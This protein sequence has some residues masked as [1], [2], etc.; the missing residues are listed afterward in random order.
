LAVPAPRIIPGVLGQVKFNSLSPNV[1]Q[2]SKML[3]MDIENKPTVKKF[4]LINPIHD[5]S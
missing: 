2:F 1:Q 5:L 4:I 3:I